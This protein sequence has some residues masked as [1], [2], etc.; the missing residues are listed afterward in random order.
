MAEPIIAFPLAQ[1]IKNDRTAL[2]RVFITLASDGRLFAGTKDVLFIDDQYDCLRGEDVRELL[3]ACGSSRSL[4]VISVDPAFSWEHLRDLR[5]AA[6][7]E[8]SSGGERI[9]DYS[10]RG[11]DEVLA[12]LNNCQPDA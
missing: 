7:C 5:I 12:T 6:G 4:Q 8:N 10:L 11:L 3:E 1:R 9:V 2:Q